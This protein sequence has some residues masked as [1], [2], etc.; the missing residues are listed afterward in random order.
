[1]QSALVSV[2]VSGQSGAID[3][4][5]AALANTTRTLNSLTADDFMTVGFYNIDSRHNFVLV[6]NDPHKYYFHQ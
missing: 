6:A 1:M 5:V 2:P 4:P 3:L